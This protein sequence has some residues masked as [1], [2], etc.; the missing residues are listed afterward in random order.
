MKKILLIAFAIFATQFMFAQASLS[1]IKSLPINYEDAE[2]K[3][4]FPG[5]H[6]EFMK[7]IG[8]NFKTPEVEGL[9]GD[10]KVSFVVETTG[11]ITEIKILKDIGSGT[12]DEAKRVISKSPNW[13][14]GEQNGKPV[15]VTFQLPITI[16]GY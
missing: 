8:N 11:K 5:G 12:G 9:S 6:N 4:E 1:A 13:T 16:K 2:V 10:V 3:P 14:P 7:F 15:R